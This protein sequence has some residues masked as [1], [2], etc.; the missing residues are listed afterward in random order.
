MVIDFFFIFKNFV[1]LGAPRVLQALGK[2]KLYPKIE[3]FSVGWGAN[4]DPVRGYILVFF[5]SLGCIL[6]GKYPLCI[7]Y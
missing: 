4:N 3:F 6:I 1:C 2:D 7:L 5:V